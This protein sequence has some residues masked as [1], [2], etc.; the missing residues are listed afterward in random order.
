MEQSILEIRLLEPFHF[1][2]IKSCCVIIV[3]ESL[4]A[5]FTR[6]A[7]WLLRLIFV[8]ILNY[9]YL[10]HLLYQELDANKHLIYSDNEH[11]S[12]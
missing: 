2:S 5:S 8:K 11:K 1:W 3:F 4:L 7:R 6:I 12:A 10:I 9:G